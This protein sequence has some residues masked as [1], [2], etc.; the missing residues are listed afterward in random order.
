M[1]KTI[2]LPLLALALALGAC[3]EAPPTGPEPGA[4][5]IGENRVPDHAAA[6]N[7]FIVTL[8]EGSRP[9]EVAR[10]H[11][12]RPDFVYERVV[13]G[14]AGSI[15]QAAREGLMRDQRV[16][17]IERDAAVWT[18][19]D[20][21]T[22]SGVTWGLDRVDQRDL[23][24]DDAYNYSGTG[25]NVSIYIVDTG[26]RH[27]HKD[28]EGRSEPGYDAWGRDGEDCHGH[29]THLAGTAAS[30]TY[31]VAKAATLVSVRVLNCDGVGVSSYVVAG[32]EWIAEHGAR[33]GVVNLSFAGSGSST[34]DEAIQGLAEK[35]ILSV[36]AGGNSDKDACGLSP[37]R[38]PDAIT[39]AAS[40]GSDRRA[41]FSNWG[42]CID[43]FA[44]GV[45]ITSTCYH[46]DTSTCRMSGTSMAAPHAAGVAALYLSGSPDA[47]SNE[48]MRAVLDGSTKETVSGSRS[49]NNHMLYSQLGDGTEPTEDDDD[50]STDGD[51]DDTSTDGDGDDT[52][53]DGEDD[54]S[55]PLADFQT[56]CEGLECLFTE[57][58][59][60]DVVSWAWDFG[61][62][63]TSTSRTPEHAYA[64]DGSYAVRLEVTDDGG[65][66][67]VVEKEVT[68]EATGGIRLQGS[69]YKDKGR[70]MVLLEWGG[71]EGEAVDIYRDGR[72]HA[73]VENSGSF[74]DETGERGKVSYGYEVCEARTSTCSDEVTVEN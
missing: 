19:G 10:D 54:G 51:G 68:V 7:R 25:E 71:A 11:G 16:A 35:G 15:A 5:A 22:Q 28:F 44:P 18:T 43:V 61:D 32:L 37:A 8:R 26:I 62:G 55:A 74:V 65:L 42:D 63:N 27:S 48:V 33:P 73:T 36:A 70:I 23:P 46:S 41:S 60:G 39:V 66:T 47:S 69:V 13:N 6:G 53:T 64:G 49:G 30:R 40:D 29:G 2:W 67:D 1:K 38:S 57:Q 4:D 24:L 50:T 12:V 45:S 58:S 59:D 31:G 56:A 21:T 72:L 14:F 3:Q 20:V 34:I 17:R 9:D 52:S